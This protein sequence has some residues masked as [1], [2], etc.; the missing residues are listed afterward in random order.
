MI[1]LEAF[2]LI[3]ARSDDPQV[4]A[5]AAKA[6]LSSG[7]A[8]RMR[9]E[10]LLPDALA[11]GE[12][13]QEERTQMTALLESDD[14]QEERRADQLVV[15]LSSSEKIDLEQRAAALGVR[16]SDYVRDVLFADQ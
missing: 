1:I 10:R 7:Q 6:R 4:Q 12:F 15:R 16:L 14:N 9:F 11:S 5:Q 8:Q 2:A 3:I 13:S